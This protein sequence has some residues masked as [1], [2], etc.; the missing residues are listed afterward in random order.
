[1]EKRL[2]QLF[3]L[4][5]CLQVFDGLATYQ[6]LKHHWDEGNP[7]IL[8]WVPYLGMGCTLLL[9][10]AKACGFLVILR[11]LGT[12]PLVY[13]ALVVLATVYTFFSFI[14]WLTRIVSLL[15]T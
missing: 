11:R 7:I 15:Y 9:F 4:N 2:H 12:A 5:L 3:L 10:K 13:E 8:S 6:G 1:M 14:P